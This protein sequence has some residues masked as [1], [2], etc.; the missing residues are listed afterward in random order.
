LYSIGAFDRAIAEMK[1]AVDLDPLAPLRR[2]NLGRVQRAAGQRAAAEREFRRALE[3]EPAFGWP[4]LGL[5]Q[6]LM[7][8]G[9]NEEAVREIQAA[10]ALARSAEQLAQAHVQLAHAHVLAGQ[11]PQAEAIVRRLEARND[12]PAYK[13]AAIHV[14]LGSPSEALRW[15][16]RAH[17]ARDD[18]LVYLKIDQRFE[19]LR[20]HPAFPDLIRRIGIPD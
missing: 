19:S 6:M 5:A 13:V 7:E 16:E 14:A 2:W 1:S 15:L 11:R 12:P 4:H 10:I 3:L 8:Q 20:S 17:A 18:E 9:R